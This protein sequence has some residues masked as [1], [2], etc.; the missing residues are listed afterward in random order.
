MTT[1]SLDS[2]PQGV[3]ALIVLTDPVCVYCLDLVQEGVTS[4]AD[5]AARAAERIGVT[6]SHAAAVLDGLVGVGYVGRS[7]LS[8]VVDLGMADFR[9]HL[10]EAMDQLDWLRSRG[11]GRQA[12]DVIAAMDA[13]YNARSADPAKRLSASRFRQSAA[14][15]RH[16]ARLEGRTLGQVPVEAEPE[17]ARA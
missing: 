7:G 9:Q 4:E 17:A 14:G 8:E 1:S 16:A 13:A 12:D 10:A 2:S 3:Q 6:T 5:V 15:R 11:E